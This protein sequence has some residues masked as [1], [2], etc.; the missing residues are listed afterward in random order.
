MKNTKQSLSVKRTNNPNAFFS[1]KLVLKG[2]IAAVAGIWGG[3]MLVNGHQLPGDYE[4]ADLDTF[5][6]IIGDV[7]EQDLG[8]LVT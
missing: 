3:A 8:L 4:V 7:H 6:R 2:T 1:L 5:K